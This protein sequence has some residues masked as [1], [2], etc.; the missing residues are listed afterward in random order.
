[1]S[2]PRANPF[3]KPDGSWWWYDEEDGER[4]PFRSQLD[5][6]REL[7]GYMTFLER[8]PTWWQS[9]W[10]PIRYTVWPVIRESIRNVCASMS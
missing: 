7:V 6:L 2:P 4:G 10:W 1:M 8:G 9:V 3:Q 5:A